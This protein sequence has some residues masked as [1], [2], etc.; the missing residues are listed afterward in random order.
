MREEREERGR[1]GDR[2]VE[3]REGRRRL[4]E[5]PYVEE[6]DEE[7][8]RE[9]ARMAG[10]EVEVARG[11]RSVWVDPIFQL[12]KTLGQFHTLVT[13]L[14]RNERRF[15]QQFRMTVEQFNFLVERV[16]PQIQRQ[17]TFWR[18]AISPAER[19]AIC[20]R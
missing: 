18:E 1:E 14:R 20:L 4:M 11:R 10:R 16:T 3:G 5:E 12:R 19:L 7:M 6:E 17:D 15:K 9:G 8:D 2:R 13:E